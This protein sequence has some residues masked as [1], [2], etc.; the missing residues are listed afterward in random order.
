MGARLI[1]LSARI[2]SGFI[3]ILIMKS[4]NRICGLILIWEAPIRFR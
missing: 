3:Q 4:I 2:I 1:R